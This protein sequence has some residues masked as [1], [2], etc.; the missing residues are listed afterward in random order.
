V[1]DVSLPH[2]DTHTVTIAAGADRVWDVLVTSMGRALSGRAARTYA[3][4]M[5]ADHRQAAGPRP[6]ATGSTTPG[7]RVVRADRPTELVLTG[8]HRL[9]AYEM[10]FELQPL[11]DGRTALACTTNAAFGRGPGRAYQAL[12]IGSGGHAIATRR[13][14]ATLRRRAER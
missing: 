4:V 8:R 1:P 6:L 5:Q 11:D 3:R 14:L 10:V 7:F 2:I 9:A 13:L 12:V